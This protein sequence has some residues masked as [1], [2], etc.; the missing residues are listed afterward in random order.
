MTSNIYI[1]NRKKLISLAKEAD[2]ILIGGNALLS[3]S[4]DVNFDFRQDSNMLYLTGINEPSSSLL[5]ELST[6]KS[7]IVL[8]LKSNIQIYFDGPLN[9]DSLLKYSGCNGLINYKELAQKLKDKKV[10]FNLPPKS[11]SWGVFA[12]PFRRWLY[13]YLKRSGTSFIDIRPQ[14]ASL[15]MIKQPY[16]INNILKAVA[17]TKSTLAHLIPTIWEESQSEQ[18]FANQISM[19]FIEKGTNHRYPPVVAAGLNAATIHHSPTTKKINSKDM[20]LVDVGA[21]YKGYCADISR[22][23]TKSHSTLYSDLVEVQK[24]LISETRPGVLIKDLHQRSVDLLEQMAKKHGLKEPIKELYP[25]AIGHHLGLDVHDA[26]DY[27]VPLQENMV[28]TIEPGIYSKARGFGYRVEDDV[29]IT[30][31][32]AKVL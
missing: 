30:K 20:L 31:T 17:I 6:G 27:K 25:H 24:V 11:Q 7:Y 21:E 23:Y 5:I 1:N 14:L 12:N 8:P 9:T 29:L 32:G 28:I 22:T 10:Y 18:D 13:N 19:R 2:Y 3:K 16:E 4:S 15:R 26:A